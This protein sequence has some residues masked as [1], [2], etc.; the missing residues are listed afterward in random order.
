[1]TP[2]K[3]KRPPTIGDKK[4][5]LNHLV[6]VFFSL[7]LE[8]VA[9]SL[10]WR[11]LRRKK[12]GCQPF[13]KPKLSMFRQV[14]GVFVGVM[15][16]KT[17]ASQGEFNIVQRS[18]FLQLQSSLLKFYFNKILPTKNATP[19][20]LLLICKVTEFMERRGELEVE[21]RELRADDS[22]ECMSCIAWQGFFPGP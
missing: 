7:H 15:L 10:L 2:S 21:A 19:Q 17:Q 11:T 14:G 8:L 20:R 6:C 13:I 22:L 9:L 3:V 12:H 1:M 16:G 4:V 5:T 18:I